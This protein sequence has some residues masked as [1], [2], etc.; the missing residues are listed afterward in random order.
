[1]I[2]Q[3]NRNCADT[4]MKQMRVLNNCYI[5]VPTAFTPNGDALNEYL[6]PTNAFKAADL[7]FRV[8]NRL[9]QV[10]FETKDNTRKWDGTYKGLLQPS[11]TY[12]WTLT[13]RHIDTNERFSSKGTSVLIR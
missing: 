2:V 10:V 11:G 12:V 1:M 3:N 4:I 9:G 5:A 13:Y 7:E 6:Y 8:Y